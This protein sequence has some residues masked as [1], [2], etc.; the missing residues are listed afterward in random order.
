MYYVAIRWFDDL[1]TI[2]ASD[3]RVENGQCK[4]IDETGSEQELVAM[5]PEKGVHFVG[6]DDH[7][8]FI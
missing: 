7:F 2:D 8:E 3:V 6:R 5:I 1:I 4:F